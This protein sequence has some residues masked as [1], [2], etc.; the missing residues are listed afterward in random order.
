[1]DWYYWDYCHWFAGGYIFCVLMSKDY[2]PT[3]SPR[4]K[5]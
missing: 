5:N 4:E 2:E 3:T 1:M